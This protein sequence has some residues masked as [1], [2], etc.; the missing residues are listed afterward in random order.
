[1]PFQYACFVSY[2]HLEHNPLAERFID[3]LSAALQG[4]LGVWM[5][6]QLFVDSERMRGGTFF[7]PTLADALCRSVCMLVVYTPNYFSLNHVY[8]AREY[9]AMEKLEAMRLA[10]LQAPRQFE[11][12]IIPVILRGA[13]YLPQTIRDRRQYYSFERFSLRSRKIAR[14][15]QFERYVREI[16]KSIH[17]R[18]IV[19]GPLADEFTCDCHNF[20]FPT[21]EEVR[22]WVANIEK[23]MTSA[24]SFPFR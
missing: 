8:C 12:L 5:E 22:P 2:R 18:K 23:M 20:A 3:D 13:E 15:A 16:A 19:L 6:E 1:M 7:N 11:G 4:E 21:E 10:R 17:R 9:R 24:N 14:D